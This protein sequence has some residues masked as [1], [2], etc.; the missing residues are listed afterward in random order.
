MTTPSVNESDDVGHAKLRASRKV[1]DFD[2]GV[3]E[4][5]IV[6]RDA[7]VASDV[8]RRRRHI[9]ANGLVS[10]NQQVD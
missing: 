8:S 1:P 7:E 9:E 4:G 10:I 5:V 6:W 2:R 3:G